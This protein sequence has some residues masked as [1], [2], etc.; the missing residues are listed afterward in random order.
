[1]V[2]GQWPRLDAAICYREFWDN[3]ARSVDQKFKVCGS[4]KLAAGYSCRWPGTPKYF[5][6]ILDACLTRLMVGRAA[7]ILFAPPPPRLPSRE[8]STKQ[9]RAGAIYTATSPSEP[10]GLG[11]Y[12]LAGAVLEPRRLFLCG[13]KSGMYR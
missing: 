4:L 3:L 10:R 7:P 13:N 8:G 1:M 9:P 11:V 5:P 12:R 6:K 2:S